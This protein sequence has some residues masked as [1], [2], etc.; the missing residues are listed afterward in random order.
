VYEPPPTGADPRGNDDSQALVQD[1]SIDDDR[2]PLVDGLLSPGIR[3][4]GGIGHIPPGNPARLVDAVLDL[5]EIQ[6]SP[7]LQATVPPMTR[8]P[9][10]DCATD[11]RT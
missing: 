10:I 5:P 1:R 2:P 9:C 8:S 7:G 4:P 11:V 3:R 6:D